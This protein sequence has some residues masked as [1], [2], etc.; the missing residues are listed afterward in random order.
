MV[1][2][3]GEICGSLSCWA[4]MSDKGY[5]YTDKSVGADGILKMRLSGGDP[6]KG[7]LQVLG[8]NTAGTMPIGVASSLENEPGATVQV[9]ASDGQCFATDRMRV[10]K[11]DGKV[12]SAVAP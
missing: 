3:A 11:A 10:K 4:T 8:K 5:K 6:G 2:R 7:K 12:F 9:L 1:A